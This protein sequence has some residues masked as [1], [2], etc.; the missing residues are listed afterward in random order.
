VQW[1]GGSARRFNQLFE[2]FINDGYRMVQ[3]ASWPISYCAISHPALMKDNFSKL[4]T[5]LKKPGL[6]NAVKRNS[7]RLLQHI[8]IPQR[9][10]GEVMVI[11][12]GFLQSPTE[13]VAVKVFSLTVLANLSKQYP[14][15][16]S[17]IKLLV[18]E[19]LPY[20]T[21]AFKSRAKKLFDDNKPSGRTKN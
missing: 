16:F 19:Q 8:A 7:V 6:H 1:V 2:L 5:N 9:Y 21:A 12:F 17:E 18:E 14:E 3:R 15:I 4:I 20:Q 10:H 11:C 13:P